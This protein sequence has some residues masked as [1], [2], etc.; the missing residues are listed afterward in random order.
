ME[1]NL[2][3]ENDQ[4]GGMKDNV[5]EVHY[6]HYKDRSGNIG[7]I[8]FGI[9]LVIL[10]FAYLAKSLGLFYFEL[11]ILQLWPILLIFIGLS[12]MN[13]RGWLSVL[14]GFL[15]TFIIIAIVFSSVFYRGHLMM[16]G[17]LDRKSEVRMTQIEVKKDQGLK[18]AELNI[19][20]VI[21]DIVMRGGSAELVKGSF[22]SD[23]LSLDTK[24]ERSDG[25]QKVDMKGEGEFRGFGPRISEMDLLLSTDTPMSLNIKTG[26]AD[27]DL[28]FKDVNLE[29]LSIETGASSLNLKLGDKATTSEIVIEA[30]ASSVEIKVPRMVGARINVDAGLTTKDMKD[31]KQTGEKTYETD[32]FEKAAKKIDL[33]LKMGVSSLKI[34]RE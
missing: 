28:D 34:E 10:G 11:S 26:A 30:G 17:I 33:K 4:A 6:H 24:A 7:S 32:G 12:V 16:H 20:G 23:F 14:I 31:F 2:N 19:E 18:K 8:F 25:K 27:M 3:R 5:R 13:A 22:G 29:S 15:V 21:G 9:V 1:N